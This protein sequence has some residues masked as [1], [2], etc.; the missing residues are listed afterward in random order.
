MEC[1]INSLTNILWINILQCDDYTYDLS[2]SIYSTLTYDSGSFLLKSLTCQ[3]LKTFQFVRCGVISPSTEGNQQNAVKNLFR[4]STDKGHSETCNALKM[5]LEN[6][7]AAQEDVEIKAEIGNRFVSESPRRILSSKTTWPIIS[8]CIKRSE[9]LFTILQFKVLSSGDR[10]S[11]IKKLA[12]QLMM[13][14]IWIL[15]KD[16]TQQRIAAGF[17]Y[18]QLTMAGNLRKLCVSGLMRPFCLWCPQ[19]LL[20]M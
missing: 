15:H 10:D 9:E 3:K 8:C 2:T 13:Q 20:R 12:M 5:Y 19:N 4:T 11:T 16:T 1:W 6:V 17:M 7:L 14:L 18:Q